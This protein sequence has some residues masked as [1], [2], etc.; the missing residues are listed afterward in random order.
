[1]IIG[2]NLLSFWCVCGDFNVVYNEGGEKCM[3]E[4]NRDVDTKVFNDFI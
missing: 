1:M 2:A 4:A 3:R